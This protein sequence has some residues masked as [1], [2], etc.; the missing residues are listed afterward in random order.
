MSAKIAVI[1]TGGTISAIGRDAFDLHDYDSNGIMLGAADLIAECQLASGDPTPVG[2]PFATLSSTRIGFP[3]WQALARLCIRTTQLDSDVAGIVILHGTATL[4]ETAFFLHLTLALPIPVVVVGAQRPW[5][6]LS[7]D[8]P[9]NLRNALRVAAAPHARG[10]G[11][12]VLL[13]DEIHAARDV[14]KA[15]TLRLHGFQSPIHGVL[16]QADP[17]Q[18]V[19]YRRPMRL[20]APADRF[21]FEDLIFPRIDILY[22]HAEA[23]DVLV[24]A[25]IDA[26]AQGLISAGFA[27]GQTTPSQTA[28]LHKAIEAGVI[29]VQATRGNFGRVLYTSEMK[30]LGFVSANDL[31]PQKAR[32]LLGLALMRTSD[33]EE[34]ARIFATY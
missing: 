33:S 11:V 22:A 15:S 24:H 32:I 4:E 31:A 28:A 5:N 26:G 1:G 23:D 13:N 25:A 12:L 17:D 30:E 14:T 8:G 18:I 10:M 27:P 6:G 9:L 21:A 34:I 19:F 7:S 2:V 29:V 3:E 16:G 20:I